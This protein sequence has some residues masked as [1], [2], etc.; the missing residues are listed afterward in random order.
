M[1]NQLQRVHINLKNMFSQEV[2]FVANE[3]Y[4]AGKP[5]IKNF[6]YKITSGDTGFQLFQT[7]ELDYSGF[8]ANPENIDQLKGL[9]F[10]NINLESSSDIAYIYV[11][12][13]KSY[14]KDK[15]YAKHLLMD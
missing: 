11:N 2:R 5:K 14:L 6:I 3:H 7:G 4:Y 1:G 12:N 15:R 8:R 9:E 10:A 13:K